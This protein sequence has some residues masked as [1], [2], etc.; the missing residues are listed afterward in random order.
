MD[1]PRT[2][3]AAQVDVTLTSGTQTRPD[4]N[5]IQDEHRKNNQ[6]KNEFRRHGYLACDRQAVV[7]ASALTGAQRAAAGKTQVAKLQ[8]S[9]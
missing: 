2:A 8:L 5:E 4:Q 6:W 3:L 7:G 1:M 9:R